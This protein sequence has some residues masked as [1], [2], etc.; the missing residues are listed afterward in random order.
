LANFVVTMIDMRSWCEQV[1]ACLSSL[2]ASSSRRNLILSPG[3]T[4]YR[5]TGGNQ[6]QQGSRRRRLGFL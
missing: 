1:V 5:L 3:T 2:L 6:P 4:G